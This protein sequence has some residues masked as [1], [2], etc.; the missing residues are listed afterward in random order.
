M[1]YIDYAVNTGF[2]NMLID[3]TLLVE[4]IEKLSTEPIF[5][6]YGW[7]PACVSLGKNQKDDFIDANFLKSCGFDI[8][9]RKTGGRALFHDKELTYSCIISS[10][11]IPNGD[12]VIESYKFISQILINV[13]KYLGVEL[14]IGGCPKHISKQN[15]CM[16]ISTGADLCWKD[17]KF[18]GSA[19]YRKNDYI[20]QHGSILLDYDKDRISKIFNEK[21]TFDSI[22]TLKEINPDISIEDIVSAFKKIYL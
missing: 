3:E 16:S 1:K 13:F 2:N 20:L 22:V 5:R 9:R 12:N 7:L 17:R 8:V 15:Y 10:K 11:I 14:T 21:T 4:S 6:F 19:Q 18:I